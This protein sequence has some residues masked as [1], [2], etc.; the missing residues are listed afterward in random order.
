[1]VEGR[2][3]A[4]EAVD[5]AVELLVRNGPVDI[6]LSLSEFTV[7]VL[8]PDEDLQGSPPSDQT[9]QTGGWAAPGN[10]ADTDLEL[11]EHG[12][13]AACEANVGGERELAARAARSPADR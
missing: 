3:S 1:M 6:P 11:P 9:R 2:D 4:R 5:E 13:L 10:G 7:E 8:T 12:P